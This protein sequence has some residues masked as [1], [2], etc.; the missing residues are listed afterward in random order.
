MLTGPSSEVNPNGALERAAPERENKMFVW[1]SKG[2]E[3]SGIKIAEKLGC[4][5][6]TLPPKGY[7]GDVFCFGATPSDKFKW[8]DRNFGKIYNDPRITRELRT[9]EQLTAAG[10]V[11]T[12]PQPVRVFCSGDACVSALDKDSGAAVDLSADHLKQIKEILAKLKNPDFVALDT[13]KMDGNLCVTGVV[14]GPAI[15]DLDPVVDKLV[16]AVGTDVKKE[17]EA[18]AKAASP[19]EARAVMNVLKK[20]VAQK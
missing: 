18:F 10:V 11:L 3:E 5:H 15:T 1:H 13:V 7:E 12:S 14:Y 19:E 4:D 6:G 9:P 8:E 20:M 17:F 2:T 16:D